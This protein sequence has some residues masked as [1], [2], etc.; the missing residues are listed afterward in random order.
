MK[1]YHRGTKTQGK[2]ELN[3][4]IVTRTD[5]CLIGLFNRK[6][7]D[8]SVFP[9]CLWWTL[10]TSVSQNR[11]GGR[12]AHSSRRALDLP[13]VRFVPRRDRGRDDPSKGMHKPPKW[14]IARQ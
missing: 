11:H 6:D 12:L 5:F 3:S 4:L 2:N 13:T 7:E 9:V 1:I 10:T 8:F 14:E